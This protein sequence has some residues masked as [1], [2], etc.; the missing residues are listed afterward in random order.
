MKIKITYIPKKQIEEG[1]FETTISELQL[2]ISNPII[3]R[4]PELEVAIKDIYSVMEDYV[5][6]VSQD[7][8]IQ[9]LTDETAFIKEEIPP[10]Y[11]NGYDL[12][13]DEIKR[14]IY[15]IIKDY[16]ED[17]HIN[18]VSEDLKDITR[19]TLEEEHLNMDDEE[20][21]DFEIDLKSSIFNTDQEENHNEKNEDEDLLSSLF[22]KYSLKSIE[23]NFKTLSNVEEKEN[24]TKINNKD[25]ENYKSFS[26]EDKDNFVTISR[27]EELFFINDDK[28]TTL[29]ITGMEAINF[30]LYALKKMK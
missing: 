9:A 27:F 22:K 1:F 14:S 11:L 21:I 25:F 20:W 28:G 6:Y 2:V 16:E 15:P 4:N 18:I 7:E 30:I 5:I 13:I 29:T 3:F 10:I 12:E 8:L 19:L 26:Y 17:I 24:N 23:D